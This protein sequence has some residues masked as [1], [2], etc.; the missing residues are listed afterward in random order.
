MNARPLREPSL[1]QAL[2][3][4]LFLSVALGLAVYLYK[5]DAS[6]GANQISLLL[7]AGIAAIIG[8]RNGVQWD[9]IQG[10]LVHGVSLAVV[11]IFILLAVGA[12]IG[13]WIL[14]GTV[15]MMI[16]YGMKLLHPTYFYPATCLV[17]AIVALTIG[18]SW[19]VAG[20]LGVALIGVAQGL[21]MSLP[22]TAGA[23]ISGAYFGDKMSPLSDT[24]NIAPAAAGS[25]L[26]AHIRHMVWTTG[27]SIVIALLLFTVLGFGVRGDGEGAAFGDLPAL[28]DAQFTL[29]WY[30][31]LPML[32]VFALAIMRFPA[33]PTIMIGALLGAVFAVVFQPD[34][35]IA[36]AGNEALARPMAL[37]SGAWKAMF[38]GYQAASGN[39]ALDE[40]LS[41]GGMSS[42]LNT[43]WLVVCA[44]GFGA[45]MERTGLLERM[46]RSV[47]KAA[48]STG[49]LIAA[50]LA[51]AFGANV[52]TAD[53]Y[54]SI[55]LTGRLFQ[56]EYRRRGLDP[57][58]LSRALE[59]A[60]TMT[61]PLIPWNTCGAYMA[62]TLGVATLDYLPYAFFNLVSPLVALVLA[63]A[64]FKILRLPDATQA[65]TPAAATP[66]TSP[67]RG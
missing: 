48:R 51:T 8:L 2:L 29:G 53:Q 27:P 19:T 54:M 64:G 42:M 18:S 7:A 25:E 44:M 47:L 38:D 3:P 63:Y 30:L 46:I 65:A 17:C 12:L 33:F 21:D 26:F 52:V 32:V 49:S 16:V 57:V 45:V 28:L 56:P 39:A 62:A 40:L 1:W 50:T 20:T 34:I 67:T 9:D 55:V 6:Y 61:S 13:T 11:P 24:T 15:P 4:L 58:N 35:V 37:L 31:L 60:G 36:L 66:D 23:V 41:R 10:T 5:D 43:V 14:S 59:D 22:V